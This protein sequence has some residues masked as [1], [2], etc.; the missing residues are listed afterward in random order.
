[1]YACSRPERL[2]QSFLL[3]EE[4][5]YGTNGIEISA[6]IEIGKRGDKHC[7]ILAFWLSLTMNCCSSCL[8]FA[9][10]FERS[11]FCSREDEGESILIS[12]SFLTCVKVGDTVYT[13]ALALRT[14]VVEACV[15]IWSSRSDF[16]GLDDAGMRLAMIG[17]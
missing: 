8:S 10:S 1:M 3:K 15:D 16:F 5:N 9:E 14:S 6:A 4:C 17:T 7:C 13:A 12:L 11:R 2:S